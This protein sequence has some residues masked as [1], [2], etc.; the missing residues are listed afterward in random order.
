MP[1]PYLRFAPVLALACVSAIATA[2]N[3]P[4]LAGAPIQAPKHPAPQHSYV[5]GKTQPGNAAAQARPAVAPANPSPRGAYPAAQAN[6]AT[7]RNLLPVRP[8]RVTY[9]NGLLTIVADNSTLA[10]VLSEVRRRTGAAIEAPASVGGERVVIS[11]GPAPANNVLTTLLNGSR[12]DYIILGSQ[13]ASG[14]PQR[15]ILRE[16]QTLAQA[17]N[18]GSQ[19]ANGMPNSPV[20][21]QVPQQA[22]EQEE[23]FVP[24][25]EIPDEVQ[26]EPQQPDQQTAPGQQQQPGQQQVKTPE[27]LLQELQQMQ[28]QQQQQQQQPQHQGTQPD[29]NDQP[30]LRPQSNDEFQRQQ[31]Q[32]QMQ[33]QQQPPDNEAP[34]PD[35]L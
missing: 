30:N 10:D 16:K 35:Q 6:T 29:G 8:P 23:E 9:S 28:Q 21:A 25:A 27:Q 31:Q 20:A 34:P 1:R 14:A 17:G 33:P 32:P 26:Q 4:E 11:I 18:P 3:R 7:P 24:E 13:Q 2:Q 22:P 12:F 5:Q 15:L 19:H